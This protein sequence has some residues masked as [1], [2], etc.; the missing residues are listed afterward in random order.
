M[1]KT[2][3]KQQFRIFDMLRLTTWACFSL[4]I[5]VAFPSFF[6]GLLYYF[7]LLL[8]TIGVVV[9]STWISRNRLRTIVLMLSMIVFSFSMYATFWTYPTAKLTFW[10]YLWFDFR[11]IGKLTFLIVLANLFPDVFE[12]LRHACRR[13]RPEQRPR[14][15][16]SLDPSRQATAA[17]LSKIHVE[18][19]QQALPTTTVLSDFGP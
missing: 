11:N 2:V 16:N 6:A 12:Y 18:A 5:V 3:N 17:R 14:H 19:M 13:D 7:L 4:A 9:L 10:D 8:P 1:N 15:N